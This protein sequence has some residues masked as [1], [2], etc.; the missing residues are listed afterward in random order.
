[1]T[2]SWFVLAMFLGSFVGFGQS[3]GTVD[4]LYV[5]DCGQGRAAD[6]S[7]WSPGVNVGVPIDLVNNCYLRGMP[8]P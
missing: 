1:M 4:R 3:A 7:R 2:R 5:L 6:Q 8:S